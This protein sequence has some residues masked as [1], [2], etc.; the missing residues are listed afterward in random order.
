MGAEEERRV[1]FLIGGAGDEEVHVD[2]WRIS[3]RGEEIVGWCGG[4]QVDGLGEVGERRS[5]FM[6]A[7]PEV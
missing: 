2:L 6:V 7:E 5:M 3:G 1:Y 4:I